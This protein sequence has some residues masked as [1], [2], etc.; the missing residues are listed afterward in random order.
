[1][2]NLWLWLSVEITNKSADF[3]DQLS[4]SYISINCFLSAIEV[5][6]N[7]WNELVGIDI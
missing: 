3:I 6:K 7:K 5:A 1:M 4:L 2:P